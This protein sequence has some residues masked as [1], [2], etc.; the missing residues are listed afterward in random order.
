MKLFPILRYRDAKAAH[1]WLEAA[2]GLEPNALHEG[3]GGT[4]AHAQMRWG[5]SMVMFGSAQDD[6]IG[7]RPGQGHVYL[8]CDDPDALYARAVAAGAEVAMELTDLDYGSRD[9]SVRDPE[10]NVWSFGTYEPT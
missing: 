9:F 4:I 8:S 7:M 6:A 2:F 3:E 10:G 1:A 5:D